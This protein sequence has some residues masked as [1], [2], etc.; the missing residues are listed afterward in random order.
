MM[1][2][3]YHL[4]ILKSYEG[5]GSFHYAKLRE[6]VAKSIGDLSFMNHDD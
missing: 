6:F 5:K 2:L 1:A 3:L 4:I